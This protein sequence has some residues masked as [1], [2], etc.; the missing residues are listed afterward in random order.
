MSHKLKYEFDNN[1]DKA[2]YVSKEEFCNMLDISEKYF[3]DVNKTVAKVVRM[4]N[5]KK[6][7]ISRFEVYYNKDDIQ[8]SINELCEFQNTHING[9]EAKK[10]CS[11]L[12]E[13]GIKSILIPSHY[14]L[15][16]RDTLNEIWNIKVVYKKSE[17]DD[18][19]QSRAEID[20]K[21]ESGEYLSTSDASKMLNMS[22][23]MFL[24]LKQS[25]DMNEIRYYQ[26]FY[27]EKNVIE[28]LVKE[29]EE[30]FSEYI[31]KSVVKNKYFTPK[32]F[33]SHEEKL[34]KYEAP[35]IAYTL[36]YTS[37]MIK[38]SSWFKISEV[39]ELAKELSEKK[40]TIK[41][42]RTKAK[43]KES[44]KTEENAVINDK[45][46]EFNMVLTKIDYNSPGYDI[47]HDILGSTYFHTFQIRLNE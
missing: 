39:E 33:P 18:Y 24:K 8:K 42:E 3:N 45:E 23:R 36:E 29:Q 13:E 35:R 20:R 4:F 41:K 27:F 32:T 15:I 37:S 16:C 12:S 17:I 11:N 1:E 19:I 2:N 46:L 7:N 44:E 9:A 40:R 28:K 43:K 10:M 26:G 34:T 21:I 30:F 5:I 25:I 6:L 31:P 47:N 22:D 14:K 38:D